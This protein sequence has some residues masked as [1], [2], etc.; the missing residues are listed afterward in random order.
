MQPL[1]ESA[2]LL[3]SRDLEATRAF[4]DAK[5]TRFELTGGRREPAPDACVNGVFLPNLWFGFVAFREAGVALH[6]SPHASSF[7]VHDRQRGAAAQSTLGDYYLHIPLQGTL[8]V[9]I[10]GRTVEC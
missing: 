8:A 6:L 5:G 4:Y 10:P 9:E 2:P 7:R 3:R 1:L